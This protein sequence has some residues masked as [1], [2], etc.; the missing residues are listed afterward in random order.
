MSIIYNALKKVQRD[1]EK[2]SQKKSENNAENSSAPKP[3]PFG[4]TPNTA[5]LPTSRIPKSLLEFNKPVSP[6]KTRQ[7]FN[8]ATITA[9]LSLLNQ[10]KYQKMLIGLGGLICV[11]L[12]F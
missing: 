12:I 2:N 8:S 1:I 9:A 7:T 5:I 3:L 10:K 6:E 11:L 4:F